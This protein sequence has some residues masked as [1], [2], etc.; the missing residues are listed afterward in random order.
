MFIYLNIWN[1]WNIDW[2]N[3]GAV[4]RGSVKS[5]CFEINPRLNWLRIIRRTPFRVPKWPVWSGMH[6]A[7]KRFQHRWPFVRGIR[8]SPV[9]SHHY[10]HLLRD[11]LILP[12]PRT[13]ARH[14][15]YTKTQSDPIDAINPFLIERSLKQVSCPQRVQSRA[16]LSHAKIPS[17][18]IL[19]AEVGGVLGN[20]QQWWT[21][22]VTR[23]VNERQLHMQL[24]RCSKIDACTLDLY[25]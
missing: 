8:R 19:G 21:V 13:A 16:L 10:W 20:W 6:M 18:L 25:I 14:R 23:W 4:T 15:K 9:V 3:R 11:T 2:W 22:N 7:W 12:E 5:I 24:Q 17:S 1:K